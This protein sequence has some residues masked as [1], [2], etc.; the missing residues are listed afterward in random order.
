MMLFSNEALN[1]FFLWRFVSNG[2]YLTNNSNLTA[3]YENLNIQELV[4][5]CLEHV[6]KGKLKLR[7]LIFEKKDSGTKWN[8]NYNRK[9]S[10]DAFVLK[11]LNHHIQTP[12]FLYPYMKYFT[13]ALLSMPVGKEN[14]NLIHSIYGVKANF[15]EKCISVFRKYMIADNIY[16]LRSRTTHIATNSACSGLFRIVRLNKYRQ[17]RYKTF[18]Q[19]GGHDNGNLKFKLCIDCRISHWFS[20]INVNNN[21]T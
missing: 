7:S 15:G 17:P 16:N 14:F 13:H 20:N 8:T 11:K 10:K 9:S 19:F 21:L 12:Y 3:M 1:R 18:A 2:F 4:I 6:L 5:Q